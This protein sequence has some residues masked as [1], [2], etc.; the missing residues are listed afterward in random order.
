M[1][2]SK[3]TGAATTGAPMRLNKFLAHAGVASRRGADELIGKGNV[4]VNGRTVYTM[5]VV[6]TPGRDHVTVDGREVVLDATPQLTT[7]ML[8]KPTGYLS[9]RSDPDGRPTIF[10]LLPPQHHHLYPVGR[11]D[12]DSEGLMLLSDDGDLT[13]RLTHP[14]FEHEKEY[15][16]QITGR[17]PEPALR[18][19]RKGVL[20]EDGM[21]SA[22]VRPLVQ[23]PAEQR[24]WVQ[25]DPRHWW[26]VFILHEGRKR[27]VRR[28]C[29]AVDLEVR[30]LIRVRIASLHVGD[31]HPGKW[32]ALSTRQQRAV[33]AI[34]QAPLPAASEA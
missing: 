25:S 31:L 21:A 6:V 34:K 27:Q 28:M 13:Y 22:L 1:T 30:R 8:N 14:S 9:T 4:Q 32:R 24:F 2:S 16:V 26:L 33:E 11:L 15:W 7:L 18:K 23:I 5:G 19:L 3:P 20:L 10:S 12:L 17:A 29:E